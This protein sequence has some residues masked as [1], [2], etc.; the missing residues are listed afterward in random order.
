[1]RAHVLDVELPERQLDSSA[2]TQPQAPVDAHT[3]C[4]VSRFEVGACD[5]S[6]QR[7][8]NSPNVAFVWRTSPRSICF[9]TSRRRASRA[10]L[11][12]GEAALARLRAVASD[13]TT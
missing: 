9:S 7:D 6:S 8:Q 3:R 5:D 13:C 2:G 1:M 11:L 10:G 4:Q 12:A